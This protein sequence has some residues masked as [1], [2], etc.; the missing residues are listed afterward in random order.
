M[1]VP[2]ARCRQCYQF[3]WLINEQM[4]MPGL[5]AQTIQRGIGYVHLLRL[6]AV[7]RRQE[8]EVRPDVCRADLGVKVVRPT[9]FYARTTLEE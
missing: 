5:C 7:C 9:D 6:R 8:R 2:V 1:L 3:Y 4:Y